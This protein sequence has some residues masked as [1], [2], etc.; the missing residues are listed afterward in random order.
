MA[1]QPSSHVLTSAGV[2]E[3]VQ[4][5]V[6]LM[7]LIKGRIFPR[8]L[9]ELTVDSQGNPSGIEGL[10][11]PRIHFG[12]VGG[13]SKAYGK[14]IPTNMIVNHW[15]KRGYTEAWLVAR[16]FIRVVDYKVIEKP[17]VQACIQS[18]N[19]GQQVFDPTQQ[20]FYIVQQFR[21]RVH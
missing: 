7:D 12:Y 13:R 19:R 21:V 6:D 3:L 5:D 15:S 14:F 16:N 8:S 2:I 4:A 17:E 1:N 10:G 11:F 20:L 9:P 18:T